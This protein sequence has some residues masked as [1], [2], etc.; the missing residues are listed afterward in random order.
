MPITESTINTLAFAEKF[1]SVLDKEITREAV[2]GFML[3]NVLRAQFVGARTVKMP[4]VDM[5]GL[6][7]YKRDVG[8]ET[9][10]ITVE[11]QAF[12]LS[13]DRARQLVMDR[14]DLDETGIANLSAEIMKEFVRTKVTPEID[15]YT[16]SK[17]AGVAIDNKHAYKLGAAGGYIADL[18][19][20]VSAIRAKVGYNKELVALADDSFYNGLMNSDEVGKNIDVGTF[21]KGEIDTQVD[22]VNRVP[23][24]PVS[25]EIMKSIF[26]PTDNGLEVDA[27]AKD[28]H[29]IVLPKDACSL[30]KKT[31]TMRIFTP[32]QNKDADSYVFN[33]R[34]YYDAFVKK[35]NI[36]LIH[37]IL[38]D[39]PV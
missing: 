36:G 34:V 31:E 7:N 12:T 11:H 24:I 32:E 16:L 1:S 9:G 8:Y 6:A 4:N 37:A 30:V 17:L 10:G 5:V 20:C 19:K 27:D 33:Y 13:M 14:E 25:G 3:D 28:V 21:K 15:A 26:N 22:R 38:S 35:S 23:V 2:T 39:I 18:M 29:L